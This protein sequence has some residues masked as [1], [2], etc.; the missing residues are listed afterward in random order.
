MSVD[1]TLRKAAKLLRKGDRAGAA[2]LY[3]GILET[4]PANATARKGLASL[5]AGAVHTAPPPQRPAPH[6]ADVAL[7]PLTRALEKGDVAQAL[8]GA[9]NLV[10]AH[11]KH[12]QSWNFLGLAQQRK[13]LHED[14]LHSFG[15]ALKTDPALA[16]AHHNSVGSLATLGRMEEA[17]QAA[18]ETVRMAPGFSAGH[19]SAG[20]ALLALGRLDEARARFQAVAD[21]SRD[22]KA[23]AQADMGLGNVAIVAGDFETASKRLSQAHRALPTDPD[24]ANSYATVLDHKNR[25]DDALE[26][27]DGALK[28]APDHLGLRVTRAT[29]L[30]RAG[31]H[32]AARSA[33]NAILET[34]PGTVGARL[35]QGLCAADSGDKALARTA[36]DAAILAEPNNPKAFLERM[37]LDPPTP[38]SADYAR[39]Q[40]FI[41]DPKTIERDRTGLTFLQFQ[42]LENAGDIN[43]AF[44][45]L[46]LAN[47]GRRAAQP[48]D[49]SHDKAVFA[50]LKAPETLPASPKAPTLDTSNPS[51]PRPVL[52]VGMPRSGTSLVEQILASHPDVHP[53]GEMLTLSHTLRDFGWDLKNHGQAFD[54]S[55]LAAI[56]DSYRAAIARIADQAPVVTD[57]MPLNFRWVGPVLAAMPDARVLWTRRDARATCWSNYRQN[58]TGGGNR[59]GND[60]SDLGQYYRMHV[61][62]MEHWMA[63]FPG[64]IT[65]VPYEALTEN[66]EV[67]SR[68]LVAAAGLDWSPACLEFHKSDRIVQTASN[69]Q[70][71]QKMYTG[72]S[73]AWRQYEPHLGPLLDALDGM[74]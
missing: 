55:T 33:A 53:G 37:R 73:E 71:R 40:T 7:G 72:S 10:K 54:P 18:L 43:A 39:L 44:A 29:V 58:F 1:A 47:Q 74:T 22:P 69:A 25:F 50:Q 15:Q 56:A 34:A 20:T 46:K 42:S 57:K 51:T 48:Y 64:R 11:P 35:V 49:I 63:R 4:Y 52:I 2:N 23:R 30:L 67:E 32:H 8:A 12:A 68:K 66:Q 6:P 21:N 70:V 28:H 59:F 17:A 65:V 60:L 26:V 5:G 24:I 62:L 41:D 14:A 13:G 45:R 3:R 61:D 9:Q 19:L 36:F 31:D 38:D 16:I 27:L